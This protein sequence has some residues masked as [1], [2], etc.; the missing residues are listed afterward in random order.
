METNT[1]TLYNVIKIYRLGRDSLF[2][3]ATTTL[4]LVGDIVECR[5]KPFIL[6]QLNCLTFTKD[7]TIPK[8]LSG[9]AFLSP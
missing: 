5:A 4:L 9:P 2:P 7:T 8:T 3:N 1:R 6:H